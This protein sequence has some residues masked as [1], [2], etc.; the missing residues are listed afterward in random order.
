MCNYVLD[1]FYLQLSYSFYHLSCVAVYVT[2][3]AKIS[4]A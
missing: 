2:F 1:I 3:G 4:E